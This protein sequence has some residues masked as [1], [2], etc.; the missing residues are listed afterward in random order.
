M[1]RA[2]SEQ[3]AFAKRLPVVIRGERKIFDVQAIALRSGSAGIAIDASEAASLRASLS[4]M[5]DAHRRTLDQL[6]SAVAVF[7]SKQRLTFYN[8]SYR[9]LWNLDV[10]FLDTQPERFGD[11]RS[12]A[13]GA[14]DSGTARFPPMEVA[15]ARCLSRHRSQKR[16]MAPAGRTHAARDRDAQSR[17]RRHLSVRRR[18]RKPRSVAP[19]RRA[20]PR[21]GRNPRQSR[22]GGGRVRQQ[23]LRAPVQS[24]VREDVAAVAG[25]ARTAAAH[26]DGAGMV[27]AAVRR[28]ARLAGAARRD[29]RHRQP[30]LGRD[31]DRAQ[32]RQRPQLHDRAAAGRRH[33]ADVPGCHRYGERGAR[34]ARAERGA[35]GGRHG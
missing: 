28:R 7:D 6:S 12:A 19:V 10:A 20:D 1:A 15:P 11:P 18:D 22:R 26:H 16:R 2:L 3:A 25:R 32:G 24:G 33:I 30:Q 5:A 35:G 8:E 13:R 29:H 4:R 31:A 27:P 14:E 17:R 9:R 34:T 23:R 21:P